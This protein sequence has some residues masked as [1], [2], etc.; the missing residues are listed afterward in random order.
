MCAGEAI[1]IELL[2]MSEHF[3]DD[4]LEKLGAR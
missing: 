4:L 3:R 2:E 1:L